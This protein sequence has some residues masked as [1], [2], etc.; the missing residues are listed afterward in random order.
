M[1]IG[2]A[3][4]MRTLSMSVRLGTLAL[5]YHFREPVQQIAD[6]VRSRARF[7]VPLE[8]ERGPVGARRALQAPVKK[9][10]VGASQVRRERGRIDREAV[11]LAGDDDRA[12]LQ[13]L[14]RV[15]GAVMSELHL[16]GLGS[17]GEAHQLMAEADPEG[18]Y[19]GVDDFADRADR[20]VA[21]LGVAR[22]VGQEHPVWP[23]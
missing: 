9:R 16:H 22:T 8:T 2:P 21:G 19:P 12:A 3:P 13:V 4:M 1:T 17:G 10:D 18:R 7:G 15:V 11:V 20:V 23:E 14:H 5:F 6:V